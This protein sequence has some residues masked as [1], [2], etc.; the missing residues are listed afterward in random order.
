MICPPVISQFAAVECL[1]LGRDYCLEKRRGIEI[2]RE[3]FINQLKTLPTISYP[4]LAGAFYA[5]LQLPDVGMEDMEIV[6][7][8]VQNHRVAV[9]PGMA[10]GISDRRCLRV[11]YGALEP[12]KAVEGID[13]L[14]EGLKELLTNHP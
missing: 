3:H 1:K 13:R 9:I 11:S 7:Y 6:K 10:F 12:D 8:L 2:A 14:I 5:F 4:E